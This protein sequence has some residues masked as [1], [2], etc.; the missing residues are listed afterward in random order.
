[1]KI[2][3]LRGK[4]L[5]EHRRGGSSSTTIYIKCTNPRCNAPDKRF[6]LIIN[7]D[8]IDFFATCPFCGTE[9]FVSTRSECAQKN[10]VPIFPMPMSPIPMFPI[11]MKARN[12]SKSQ[13]IVGPGNPFPVVLRPYP[14]IMHKQ[15]SGIRGVVGKA[16]TCG[17]S[18]TRFRIGEKPSLKKRANSKKD[19][20]K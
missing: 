19:S 7:S 2:S 9:Y 15:V 6:P 10:K 18:K 8:E 20:N 13:R 5:N 16:E 3:K 17:D 12:Q 1:M 4:K 14:L 11:P